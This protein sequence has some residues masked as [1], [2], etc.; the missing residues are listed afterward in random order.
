MC[1]QFKTGY[2]LY[3]QFDVNLVI[4]TGK[5]TCSKYTKENGKKCKYITEENY[6]N[7]KKEEKRRKEQRGNAKLPEK[8]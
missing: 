5:K 3:R 4:T 1:Y 6:Q 7:T 2:Y 8:N